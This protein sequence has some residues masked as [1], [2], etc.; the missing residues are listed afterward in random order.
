MA[1]ADE[2]PGLETAIAKVYGGPLEDFVRRRDALAKELR[3]AGKH[4][5][6]SAVKALRKPSRLAW[7][8]DLA[9]L[10][11]V[12]ALDALVAAVDALVEAQTSGGDVRAA[13]AELRTVIREFANHAARAAEQAGHVLEPAVLAN[14][15]LAVLGVPGSFTAL[16]RGHLAEIP[17]AGALDFLAS[18]PTLSR[19]VPQTAMPAPAGATMGVP[20]GS[21]ER[22]EQEAAARNVVERAGTVLA[23]AREHA[24]KSQRVLEETESKLNAAELRLR[25]AEDAARAARDARE[26]ARQE[27]EVTAARL[28]EAERAFA[29]AERRLDS[30]ARLERGA[31]SGRGVR[32]G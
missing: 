5:S 32:D 26:R 10:E 14:A 23:A 29:E 6:A 1:N 19:Q 4:E 3:A 31:T 16:R 21:S 28:L 18:L 30:I 9:A 17:E 2:E 25:Q 8:L 12:D 13:N 27:A 24:E 22:A 20:A 11:T 7:A 15:V